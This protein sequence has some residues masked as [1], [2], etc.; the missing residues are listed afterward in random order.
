MSIKLLIT[1]SFVLGASGLLFFNE[2]VVLSGFEEWFYSI[3]NLFISQ[4]IQTIR[5]VFHLL[6]LFL[7]FISFSL[8]TAA[9]FVSFWKVFLSFQ[10]FKEIIRTENVLLK[11]VIPK[12]FDKTPDFMETFLITIHHN[13]KKPLGFINNYYRGNVRSRYSFEIVSS[14]GNMSFYIR[15]PQKYLISTKK[16]LFAHMPSL[17]IH[18]VEDYTQDFK[19]N[20]REYKLSAT[21]WTLKEDYHFPIKTYINHKKEEDEHSSKQYV[22]QDQQQKTKDQLHELYELFNLVSEHET[23]C[24]QYVVQKH[25]ESDFKQRKHKSF[26]EKDFWELEGYNELADKEIKNIHSNKEDEKEDAVSVVSQYKKT[27]ADDIERKKNKLFFD[28]G[29]RTL[30]FATKNN[31]RKDVNSLIDDSFN[32][33][34]SKLNKI[35][36]SNLKVLIPNNLSPLR[37]K[38]VALDSRFIDQKASKVLN[39]EIFNLFKDR[40]FFLNSVFWKKVLNNKRPKDMVFSTEELASLFHFP[41]TEIDMFN[42]KDSAA[43][44]INAPKNIPR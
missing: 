14:G 24:I 29:I 2:L 42:K 38:M 33:F 43:K 27:Q 16:S 13:M 37:K 1:I 34:N 5:V 9:A 17:V 6:F 21:E 39:L 10:Q 11:I 20:E 25:E 44:N 3:E 41:F 18:E 31:F 28:V 12:G 40:I 36:S 22:I 35:V 8:F 4:S 7:I 26:F 30:Y 15:A 32:V 19:F 23:V